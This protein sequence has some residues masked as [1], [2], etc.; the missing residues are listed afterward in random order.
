M[1][2]SAYFQMHNNLSKLTAYDFY[3]IFFHTTHRN[4][5]SVPSLSAWSIKTI[6]RNNLSRIRWLYSLI[7]TASPSIPVSSLGARIP[8]KD[9][10]EGTKSFQV[11]T[12]N[13]LSPNC[14]SVFLNNLHNDPNRLVRRNFK[15]LLEF[16]YNAGK[17]LV[18]TVE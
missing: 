13:L 6:S 11:L 14:S 5:D 9:A 12:G 7:L 16:D 15:S 17:M 10:N 1:R 4:H 2:R 8:E 3:S 18:T